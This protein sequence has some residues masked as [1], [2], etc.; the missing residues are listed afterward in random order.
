MRRRFGRP[1]QGRF[2]VAPGGT[3][4]QAHL[5]APLGYPLGYGY[6][7]DMVEKIEFKSHDGS[8]VLVYIYANMT[9]VYWW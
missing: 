9:G 1:L 5:A 4:A 7:T 2:E 3:R 8:M 6:T